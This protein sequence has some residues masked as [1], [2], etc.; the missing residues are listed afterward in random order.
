MQAYTQSI[1]VLINSVVLADHCL[2]TIFFRRELPVQ[3]FRCLWFAHLS[4]SV[5]TLVCGSH[6]GRSAPSV[7]ALYGVTP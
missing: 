5:V 6:A 4:P 3:W 1:R 7:D 2:A